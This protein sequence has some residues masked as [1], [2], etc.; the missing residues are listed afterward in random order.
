MSIKIT[1]NEKAPFQNDPDI[2]DDN[3]VLAK[4]MNEIKTVVNANADELDTVK[5]NIEN[6]QSGQNTANGDITSL[7]NRVNTLETDNSTNKTDINTLKADNETNKQNIQ[8]LQSD[9]T[10]NKANI[11]TLLSDNE[12]NKQN[13]EDL[14]TD[15]ETNKTNI[16]NKVDKVEGKGLSTEDF[17]SELKAKL[18]GLSN[19]DDTEIKEDIAEIQTEQTTQNKKIEQLDDNQIHITTEKSSNINVQDCSNLSAKIDVFGVSSQET[20]SGKNKFNIEKLTGD[21][22]TNKNSKI[23]SFTMSNCWSTIIMNN[24]SL[25]EILKPN[26]QYKCIAD[27]TLL[28]K[29]ENLSAVNANQ[30]LSLYNKQDL[31]V[32]NILSTSTKQEKDD[33]EVNT[34]KHLNV[35]FTTPNNLT[36]FEVIGYNYRTNN[37]TNEGSFKFENI[38]ILEVTE[39]D[40]TFEQ[41]GASPSPEFPSEI[42]NVT[43]NIDITVLNKNFFD[44]NDENAFKYGRRG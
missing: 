4:N 18:E 19:Y 6:L 38:M 16:A 39:E 10:T 36:G 24:N 1:F 26:T 8:S 25:Q 40:E 30:I 9:N 43:G 27:V 34:T 20:R 42:E 32:T 21:N 12:T 35:T 3:K 33:W 15:N 2:P 5:E 22:I 37:S 14:Q 28:S 23:G 31:I 13:I 44:E 29:P 11:N 17:T 7:K 41:Y